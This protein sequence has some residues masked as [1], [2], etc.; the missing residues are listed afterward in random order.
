MQKE[1][2]HNSNSHL[3]FLS[4]GYS[5]EYSISMKRSNP[6]QSALYALHGAV[7]F[8]EPQYYHW[9]CSKVLLQLGD[10]RFAVFHTF[11]WLDM[12]S[13]WSYC[14]F[15]SSRYLET[16]LCYWTRQ[17]KTSFS[18]VWRFHRWLEL[19]VIPVLSFL[20]QKS[21]WCLLMQALWVGRHSAGACLSASL[22]KSRQVVIT[23]TCLL[24][25][26]WH[27]GTAHMSSSLLLPNVGCSR[28][29]CWKG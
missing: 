27:D 26:R 9:G 10:N 2:S 11:I 17:R 20:F 12:Q 23:A 16:L 7:S 4:L 18:S 19:W 24:V 1:N 29:P 15:G 8:W 25:R 6:G 21:I 3:R 5:E 13:V 14:T 22:D 28:L